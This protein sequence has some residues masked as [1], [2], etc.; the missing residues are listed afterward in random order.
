MIDALTERAA[1][2]RKAL[3]G[4]RLAVFS[5]MGT[6]DWEDFASLSFLAMQVETITDLDRRVEN[7]E[8]TMLRIES[9]LERIASAVTHREGS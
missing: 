3:A 1:K 9:H 5:I 4:E 7:L 2:Y 6:E 8:Q